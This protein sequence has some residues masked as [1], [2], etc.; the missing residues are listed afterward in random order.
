VFLSYQEAKAET[1]TKL[2]GESKEAMKKGELKHADRV[3]FKQSLARSLGAHWTAFK[4]SK[5]LDQKEKAAAL[6]L[7]KT[8]SKKEKDKLHRANKMQASKLKR[9]AAAKVKTEAREAKKAAGKA[10]NFQTKT[11]PKR[12]PKKPPRSRR[13][14]GDSEASPSSSDTNSSLSGEEPED[15]NKSESE[16]DGSADAKSTAGSDENPDFTIEE[17]SEPGIVLAWG[18]SRKGKADVFAGVTDKLVYSGRGTTRKVETVIGQY[19]QPVVP[20]QPVGKWARSVVA[21]TND[22]WLFQ[23]NRT[24]TGNKVDDHIH[25]SDVFAIVD[26]EKDGVVVTGGIWSDG[27]ILTEGEWGVLLS[28]LHSTYE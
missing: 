12:K 6:K 3:L 7:E 2:K 19:M 4:E 16:E 25:S 21:G 20:G 15:P 27:C 9:E 10:P 22:P 11:R 28:N 13:N 26:W 24:R 8:A 17:C 1:Y 5:G 23:V 14:S 18:G